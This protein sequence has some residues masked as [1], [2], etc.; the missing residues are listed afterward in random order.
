[1]QGTDYERTI[2]EAEVGCKL[3][4]EFTFEPLKPEAERM[5]QEFIGIKQKA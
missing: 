1:M 4:A 2:R 5:S 3:C